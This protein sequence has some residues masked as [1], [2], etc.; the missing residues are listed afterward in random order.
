M[1]A[2]STLREGPRVS[3]EFVPPV[4]TSDRTDGVT[5]PPVVSDPSL[6]SLDRAA[7][8]R[9][10]LLILRS[11]NIDDDLPAIAEIIADQF[12]LQRVSIDR[13]TVP[14]TVEATPQQHNQ[15]DASSTSTTVIIPIVTAEYRAGSIQATPIDG[16]SIGVHQQGALIE[17]AGYIGA[18]ID[19]SAAEYQSATPALQ[20]KGS[21]NLLDI[22]AQI[23]TRSSVDPS[24]QATL[25]DIRRLIGAARVALIVADPAGPDLYTDSATAN[26]IPDDEFLRLLSI[27]AVRQAFDSGL[28]R[29]SVVG[30]APARTVSAAPLIVHGEPAGCLIIEFNPDHVASDQVKRVSGTFAEHL[31]FCLERERRVHTFSRQN[32]LLSLVERVTASIARSTDDDDLLGAMA[33]EIRRT[34][35]Y[36]CSIA[37]IDGNRLVFPAIE[38]SD[39]EDPPAWIQEGMPI[40]AGVIGRVARTGQAAFIRDVAQDP[41]FLDTGR[42][43][44]AEI[45]VPIRIRDTVVGVLNVEARAENELETLDF[46]ILLVLANHIGIALTNRQLIAAERESRKAIEAIQLVSTIIAETLDP[47]ESLFRIASTL[48]EILGYPV[49][50]LAILEGNHLKLKASYG[51]DPGDM[52]QEMNLETGVSGRVARTGTP[53]LIED[54][55]NVDDFVSL[56]NDLVSEI[57]VP[58]RCNGEIVGILNVEGTLANPLTERDFHLMTTF[59]EHAGVLLN[60]ARQYAALSREATLDP[61]TGVP[62]LRYFQQ[63]L[64]EQADLARQD[65][66]P[67]ALAVIDLDNLK[68]INDSHGHLVGDQVLMETARRMTARLREQ[69]LLARYAGDEFVAILPN[70]DEAQALSI[71]EHLLDGARCEPFTTESGL[72]VALSLSIGVAVFPRDSDSSTDLLR[73]ADLAMYAAKESGRNRASSFRDAQLIRSR[74]TGRLAT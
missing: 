32:M 42:G 52:P 17:I 28:K 70:T 65:G 12:G 54:T 9:I 74:E 48:G 58:I 46:E 7:L 8:R 51:Y 30:V 71:A 67:L 13:E 22:T 3:S 64:H 2:I 38:L 10:T 33:Q 60:N 57:C 5:P 59:A 14:H 63:E 66:R 27:P 6:S 4:S 50:S 21:T 62:N 68:D 69:D 35:G 72:D 43:T 24:I 36:D 47:D 23:A 45:A 39:D 18:A 49:V 61:M 41:Y 31:S 19:R 55:R 20:V 53:V 44:V 1:A 40:E 34:F 25:D 37:M 16:Q 26:L 15:R 11:S 29:A 56:R 73:A